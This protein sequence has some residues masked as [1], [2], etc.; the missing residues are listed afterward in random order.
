M[1]EMD[2]GN[3]M[4]RL[5]YAYVLIGNQRTEAAASIAD[6]FPAEVRDTLPGRLTRFLAHAAA[7]R[8]A[9]ADALVTPDMAAV[10]SATD[11]FPRILAQGYALAAMPERALYWLAI[12]IDRGFINYPF[13]ATYDPSFAGL[14]ANPRFRELLDVTRQRW[15]R[16]EP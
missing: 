15:E 8:A 7:G 12:A 3:P 2:P 10:A 13:L 14:R 4:A 11:L 5:F 9:D 16:F 6:T 1:F